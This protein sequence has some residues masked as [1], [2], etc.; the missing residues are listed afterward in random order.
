MTE[1]A[2]LAARQLLLEGEYGLPVDVEAVAQH[3]K[4]EVRRQELEDHISGVLIIKGSNAV[5]GVNKSHH[6]HRQRFTIAHEIGHDR[7]HRDTAQLFVDAAPAFFRDEQSATGLSDQEVEANAFAAELLMPDA[8]VRELFGRQ[9]IDVFDDLALRRLASQ[10]EV[11]I[12]ALTIR[13]TRL[14]L[15]RV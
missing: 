3:L 5:I 14:N 7:L 4:I 11:S 12:Q 15:L 2:I 10:F 9:P 8:V 1:R 6:V 13:L